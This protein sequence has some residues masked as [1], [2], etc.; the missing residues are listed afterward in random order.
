MSI[1][2]LRLRSST[3]IHTPQMARPNASSASVGGA[4][5]APDRGL[6]DRDEHAGY[7]HGHQRRGGPVDP[8]RGADLGLGDEPPRADSGQDHDRQ[9]DPEQP[10][11]VQVLVDEPADDQPEAAADPEDGRHQPDA[12][13]DALGG[14]LVPDDRERQRED[15]AG[16]PLDDAGH[17]Q[18]RQR[19]RQASEQGAGGQR[20]QGPQ[21]QPLLAVH[22]AELADDRGA[23][24]GREQEPGQ[25]PGDT[26]LAG[27]AGCAAAS[28]APGSPRN[29]GPRTPGP[30]AIRRRGSRS[31]G[32][33][34]L[35]A[36]P[37]AF[38]HCN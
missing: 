12:P 19:V 35:H 8:A 10:V 24:R 23:D 29:S 11:P 21:Q 18:H 5:P 37:A 6:G 27:I 32:R 31:G 2:G 3:T 28:S 34:E 22:V 30:R 14:K 9:R 33:A 1:R 15:A 17:D 38:R 13:R 7:A 20:Q 4:R 25:Q 26:R 16:H 36:G